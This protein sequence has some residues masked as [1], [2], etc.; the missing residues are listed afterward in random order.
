MLQ[1]NLEQKEA[2]QYDNAQLLKE[3]HNEVA[4]EYFDNWQSAA[5]RQRY[6]MRR[7]IFIGS[8]KPK[9]FV[10]AMEKMN[11]YLA[12]FPVADA[13]TP[14]TPMSDEE[15]LDIINASLPQNWTLTML[16]NNIRIDDFDDLTEA[17]DHYTALYQT[18]QMYQ[19]LQN[20]SKDETKS[21]KKKDKRK[22]NNEEKSNKEQQP[23]WIDCPHCGKN[24]VGP[25]S[26]C[27]TLE[28]NKNK[29]PKFYRD[30]SGKQNADHGKTKEGSKTVTF[31]KKQFSHLMKT[32]PATIAA[33]A[34]NRKRKANKDD[35]D[36]IDAFMAE[37]K[38]KEYESS[39]D[40]N[41]DEE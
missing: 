32:L 28:K 15:I 13:G 29:C 19:Q 27:W 38:L 36:E 25:A 40:S 3:V 18:D 5:R 9:I 33:A 10:E 22:R 34:S 30:P 1:T 23:K 26:N 7:D 24:H 31:S 11:K 39:S 20:S 37:M 2:D 8:I 12:Y 16:S 4:K 41:T 17:V 14:A 6:Y 35:E 21:K